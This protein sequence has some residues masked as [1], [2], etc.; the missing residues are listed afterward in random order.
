MGR[1]TG[2][3]LRGRHQTLITILS[4]YRVSQSSPSRLGHDT[5]FHQQWRHLRQTQESPNPRQQFL[6]DIKTHIL[7]LRQQNHEI[8]LMIDA[9]ETITTQNT[10]THFLQDTQLHD[11]MTIR[12]PYTQPP[13]THIRGSHR[14]DFIVATEGILPSIQ[15]TG[16]LPFD[17]GPIH[18]DHR[19]QFLDLNSNL[20]FHMDIPTL[21][22]T[23]WRNLRTTDTAARHRYCVKL[24]QNLN[25]KRVFERAQHLLDIPS[26]RFRKHHHL[27]L[28]AL[29][30]DITQAMLQA[31]KQCRRRAPPWSPL[32]AYHYALVR[33][34][35]LQV[36]ILT[37]PRNIQQASIDI[38]AD[39]DKYRPKQLRHP[40][41]P[42]HNTTL[43]QHP[44]QNLRRAQRALHSAR[45][46]SAES[47]ELYLE[48]L[49][50]FAATTSDTTKVKI[51]QRIQA[52]EAR[53]NTYSLIKAYLTADKPTSLPY[54]EVP[55][56]PDQ[57]PT[58]P[59][60]TEW[61]RIEDHATMEQLLHKQTRKH[62][63]QAQGTP[64]THGSL[65]K[66]LSHH[67]LTDTTQD[68]LDG[69]YSPESDTHPAAQLLLK[70]MTQQCPDL[71][72]EPMTEQDFRSMIRH[73]RESTTTSP[74]GRHLGHYRAL[75]SDIDEDAWPKQL[76]RPI[77]IFK[78]HHNMLH[79]AINHTH[80]YTRWTKIL[81]TLFN[82]KPGN[83]KIHRFRTIHIDEVDK[84][85]IY[86][87]HVARKLLRHAE[88]HQGIHE[89]QWGG[90]PGCMAID[91][92]ILAVIQF[93][94]CAMTQMNAV[95]QYN[96]ATAC[97]D[98]IIENLSN[99]SLRRLGCP[100]NILSLHAKS[101][102]HQR[103]YVTTSN[104]VSEH[105]NQH[106][107][108]HPFHGSGQGFCDS[109]FR[110]TAI[111][112]ALFSAY[113]EVSAS[114]PFICPLTGN[115]VEHR[116]SAFVD[117]SKNSYTVDPDATP[118]ELHNCIQM[119]ASNWEQLLYA[120]GG[121]LE[122]SKCATIPII[123]KQNRRGLPTIKPIQELNLNIHITDHTTGNQTPLPIHTSTQPYKYLGV[124]IRP[125]GDP[126][127]QYQAL[128][129]K[130]QQ[131]ANVIAACPLNRYAAHLFYFTVSLP[132][133]TYSLPASTLT[134]YQLRQ[135]QKPLITA[136][137]SKMGYRR[138]IP[139][140]VVFAPIRFGGLGLRHL[141]TEQGLQ[142]IQRLLAHLRSHSTLGKTFLFH[143]RW[144]QLVT[145]LS[146]SVLLDTRKIAGT[147]STWITSLRKFMASSQ[148]TIRLAFPFTIPPIRDNDTHLMDIITTR[149]T[150]SAQTNFNYVR[151][152]LQ[153]TTLAEIRDGT[154]TRFND[155]ILHGTDEHIQRFQQYH[156]STLDWPHLSPPTKTQWKLWNK[157]LHQHFGTHRALGRWHASPTHITWAYTMD[158]NFV[159]HTDGSTTACA[160]YVTRRRYIER[161]S[162][163]TPIHHDLPAAPRVPLIPRDDTT[164]HLT[165]PTTSDR[166]Q[167]PTVLWP[168][169]PTN[170]FTLRHHIHRTQLLNTLMSSTTVHLCIN[171]HV[172]TTGS[173]SV[174]LSLDNTTFLM[175][176]G[177]VPGM[178]RDQTHLRAQAYATTT[179]LLHL[180]ALLLEAQQLEQTIENL[181]PADDLTVR[182]IISNKQFHSIISQWT[183]Y[184]SLYPNLC[185]SDNFDVLYPIFTLRKH[186]FPQM[187]FSKYDA[188]DADPHDTTLVTECARQAITRHANNI[189]AD[190][191]ME[192]LCGV[193]AQ[194][195][196]NDLPISTTLSQTIRTIHGA[197]S[198]QPY[199]QQKH[200]WSDVTLADIDWKTHGLALS[201]LPLP[202]R[203]F[204]TKLIH[205]WLPTNH[206][207]SKWMPNVSSACPLCTTTAETT[208]HF[209]T[210]SHQQQQEHHRI[211]QQRLKQH[212]VR[213]KL[214]PQLLRLIECA[215]SSNGL[216]TPDHNNY[217]PEYHQ[218]IHN[219]TSIGWHHLLHGRISLQWRTLQANYLR[220]HHPKR[221]L[222]GDQWAT[223]L[224]VLIWQQLHA[225]WKTRCNIVHQGETA[226][227]N[228]EA[229]RRLHTTAS[230]IYQQSDTLLALDRQHI[231]EDTSLEER[232]QQ[233]KHKLT[234]WAQTAKHF[235]TQA[236]LRADYHRRAHTQPLTNYFR[237]RTSARTTTTTTTSP[238]TTPPTQP[239]QPP[240]STTTPEARSPPTRSTTTTS[241]PA[242]QA[243]HSSQS[244]TTTRRSIVTRITNFFRPASRPKSADQNQDKYPG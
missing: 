55:T 83:Y 110:W 167:P 88:L 211:L 92:A 131:H 138:N 4:A 178:R 26:H 74:S 90:R 198:I 43:T 197:Q 68:I 155:D 150:A 23:P 222:H 218:L 48:S 89:D 61:T 229:L 151:Q 224:L 219:Q 215:I 107:K 216:V 127:A 180:A 93:D 213:H 171:S 133:L 111:S 71:P 126:T 184:P 35:Q 231:T 84:Q 49:H 196:H 115:A 91:P 207:L 52:A 142:Q 114:L 172:Q 209:L 73:W 120:T 204:T 18:S 87:H 237:R 98:R 94:H 56:H 24:S 191:P 42:I 208:E 69:S 148:L 32:L 210:C 75:L 38:L 72:Y 44:K 47:R 101:Q 185:L 190:I 129:K 193:H 244:H 7:Q 67:G 30:Q 147:R 12:H 46:H 162:T 103:Y 202:L 205:G 21:N 159:Y 76:P 112:S 37:L 228:T 123:W 176:T 31:E 194:I 102:R 152:Y 99:L 17:Q 11:I 136:T 22:R 206:S 146:S 186:A 158:T 238:S 113:D 105:F 57:D 175:K 86:K 134:D 128:M 220:H 177:Q 141:Y 163:W 156:L 223:G 200:T 3:T 16:I 192:L 119:H 203:T 230:A 1:W 60:T 214:D 118:E 173:Y 130:S 33:F 59:T 144:Y 212:C 169:P 54:V 217:P 233:P 122:I 19:G 117:D 135:I 64:F 20:L 125:D 140:T 28:D 157:L 179:G 41:S 137:L 40:N 66:Q 201:R 170:T 116:T 63:S 121:R 13:N 164:F 227:I 25:T 39:I 14:I 50:I 232:L 199:L 10:W 104:G 100:S 242:R 154:G 36:S 241:R 27:I 95:F 139:R 243:R 62:F 240:T 195:Y 161:L 81:N 65:R 149:C 124:H 5:A 236:R 85:A 53:N 183:T 132:G 9:N 166:Q 221:K 143:I 45:R 96:D 77:D 8:I 51:L 235:L 226:Q 234:R 15:K 97:Y 70:H 109:P 187:S 82:K 106:S 160:A 79:L 165:P 225:R 182:V 239:H 168:L 181:P 29:D 145:G 153:V 189:N 188:S 58:A 78:L 108:R 34:W 6:Q 174:S 2:F 80:V